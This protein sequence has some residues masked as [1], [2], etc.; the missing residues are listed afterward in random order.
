[1]QHLVEVSPYGIAN[2]VPKQPTLMFDLVDE[3]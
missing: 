3:I 1:M 2:F